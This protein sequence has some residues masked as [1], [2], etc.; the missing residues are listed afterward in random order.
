[1]SCGK[2]AISGADGRAAG[3]PVRA[4]EM[5]AVFARVLVIDDEP[6]IHRLLRAALG[7]SGF[8][9]ERA[10]SA[11]EGLSLARSRRPDA[12]LLTLGLPDLNGHEV[13]AQLR[14]FS[15]VPVIMLSARNSEIDKIAALDGGADDYVIKPFAVG[16]LMARIRVA[17]RHRRTEEGASKIVHF[18]GLMVDLSRRRVVTQDNLVVLTAKEWA[19]LSLL[20]R[21]AGRVWT[22]RQLLTAVWG[23]EHSDNTQ[24]LR[25]YIATLR[26]KLGPAGQLI[27]TATGV[28]YRMADD[29][30]G[31][32]NDQFAI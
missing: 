28:G 24:Y 20:V 11:S 3:A 25:V 15:D 21:K 16:E 10:D 2:A 29:V 5:S 18:P 31:P 4:G 9:V 30:E 12:V 6:Q 1:M 8:A 22:H 17:M 23:P 14:S 32:P 19:L 26:Q 13:L 7:A 27:A